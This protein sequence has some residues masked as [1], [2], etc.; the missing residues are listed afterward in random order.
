MNAVWQEL[1]RERPDPYLEWEY[2]TRPLPRTGRPKERWCSLQIQILPTRDG[3]Y[4]PN[5]RELLEAVDAGRLDED[6]VGSKVFTIRM[7]D[8][9]KRHLCEVIAKIEHMQNLPN[10]PPV[11][12]VQVQFFI[13]RPEALIYNQEAYA[14]TSLYKAIIAGPPIEGLR[15]NQQSGGEALEFPGRHIVGVSAIGIIDDGIAFAHERF[16]SGPN[17]SRIYAIWLQ[18]VERE[19]DEDRGVVFGKRLHHNEINALL[20]NCNSE[21]E[22]YR[23]VGVTDFGRNRYNPLAARATHGTHVLDLAAGYPPSIHA[24]GG[25]I[26]AVQLPSVATI[27]T[28]G[29]T[30]GSYVLQAVRMIM[31][32]ADRLD[33]GEPVPLVI[34]FSYG[35]LAGPKN[36]TQH[37]EKALA[38]LIEFRNRTTKTVLVLP[39]GN[40]YRVRTTARIELAEAE[41]QTLDWV[42]LPDDGAPNFIEIWLDGETC[43]Q[44]PSPVEITLTPPGQDPG[45]PLCLEEYVVRLL[46]IDD[47]PVACMC[48]DIVQTGEVT[49]GR[50]FLAIGP[51]GRNDQG[52]DRAPSGRWKLSIANASERPILAHVYIQRDDTPFGYPRRGRQSYLDHEKAYGR[53]PETG[54]Y[55]EYEPGCPLIYQDTLSA[56]A[57]S[58]CAVV[59]GAAEATDGAPPADYTSS[60]PTISG[61]IPDRSAFG[62]DGDA[63]RGIF[64]AGTFSGSVVALRG[65]SVAA[66]QIVREVAGLGADPSKPPPAGTAITVP[67]CDEP[68]LGQYIVKPAVRP[69]I[70]RR[71]YPAI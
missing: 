21:D 26:L 57:T 56:I 22:I 42:V 43:G 62:D 41:S 53:D 33:G 11:D 6:H 3:N 47:R 58:P 71:R 50:V 44:T 59:V 9:E 23:Q 8:D 15:F 13:Y 63:L 49:R 30:M 34:N 52:W 24:E 4:L 25:P 61:R 5:L 20:E 68:R 1:T 32:W 69:W 14:L 12:P 60:G 7:A 38:H 29:V 45:T 31:D 39:A 54:D 17:R 64:A 67:S 19:R 51:S 66:P 18:E 35:L 16:R 40:S 48:Y 37:L 65:T 27:D 28:S 55:R 36:G 10:H 46:T 2:L 70:P